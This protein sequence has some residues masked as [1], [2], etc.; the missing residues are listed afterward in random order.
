M[1]MM[2]EYTKGTFVLMEI[3]SAATM[4]RPMKKY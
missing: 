3:G 1:A 2:S 4:N